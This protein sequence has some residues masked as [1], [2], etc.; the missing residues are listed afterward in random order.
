MEVVA[1]LHNADLLLED[2]QGVAVIGGSSYV[3]SVGD[4]V[5]I[6]EVIDEK[7]RLYEVTISFASADHAMLHEDEVQIKFEGNRDA[8]NQYLQTT[9]AH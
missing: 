3:L 5:Y 6:K 9:T 2:T 7:A 8:L 1:Y 4:K